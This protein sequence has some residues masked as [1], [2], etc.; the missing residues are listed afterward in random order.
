MLNYRELV[1]RIQSTDWYVNV[2]RTMEV[3]LCAFIAEHNLTLSLSESMVTLIRSLRP[4]DAAL[5]RLTL[6]KQKA[7]NTICQ[8][9][10]YPVLIT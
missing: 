4:N 2:R 3:K 1:K 6:G 9:F 7:T 5:S 8:V 10:G